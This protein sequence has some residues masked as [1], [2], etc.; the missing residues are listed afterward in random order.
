MIR[1]MELNVGDKVKV[2]TWEDMEQEF[3]LEFDGDIY[4]AQSF[5]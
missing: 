4:M 1:K 2:R 5:S 3:G